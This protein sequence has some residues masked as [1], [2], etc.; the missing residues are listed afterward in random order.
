MKYIFKYIYLCMANVGDKDGKRA[1][2][3]QVS[4]LP[5]SLANDQ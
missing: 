1:E 4:D 2:S 5:F 3:G